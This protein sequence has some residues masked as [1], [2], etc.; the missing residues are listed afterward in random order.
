MNKRTTPIKMPKK[1]VRRDTVLYTRVKKENKKWLEK[2]SKKAGLNLSEF[3]DELL[4]EC[5]LKGK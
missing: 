2:A 5:R 3:T 4:E 1:K